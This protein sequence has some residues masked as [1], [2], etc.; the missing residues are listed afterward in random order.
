[1]FPNDHQF[2]AEDL[3]RIWI[4]Q[5]FVRCTNSRKT[6]EETGQEYFLD[7]ANLGVFEEVERDRAS[8][9]RRSHVMCAVMHDF[10]RIISRT[11]CESLDDCNEMEML[12]TIRHLSILTDSAYCKKDKHGS[13]PRNLQFEKKLRAV[14]T[15]TRKLRTLTLIGKYDSFFF[16]SFLDVLKKAPYLRMLQISVTYAE[17]SATLC[18][19]EKSTHLR[20]LKLKNNGSGE[21]LPIHLNKYYHLEVLDAGCPTLFHSMNDLVSM[22]Y[23][24]VKRGAH[25]FITSVDQNSSCFETTQLQS[26]MN[27]VQ[28]GVFQLGNVS[29]AEAYGAKLRDKKNMEMLHLSWKD[30]LSQDEYAS[31]TC[32]ESEDNN[33]ATSDQVSEHFTDTARG[34]LEGFEPHPNLKH[35]RI[36]GY[37]GGGTTFPD[38]LSSKFSVTCMQTLHLD[39]CGECQV[40]P[41]LEMLPFLTKLKL[42][43]MWKVTQVSIPSLEELVLIQMR[44]LEKCSCSSVRNLN[45]SLRVLVIKGCHKLKA[46]PLF[47][48][49][50]KFRI[51]QKSWLSGL[52]KLAIHDCPELIVSNPLPP[53][54]RSCKLSISRVST[55]PT[56]KGSSDGELIIG[57]YEEESRRDEDS[58]ELTELDDKILAFHNLRNLTSLKI[59]G[60]GNLVSIS[61]EGLRELISLETLIIDTCENLFPSTALP[62][63]GYESMAPDNFGALPS[64]KR[65]SF[66]DSG[67]AGKWLSLM[68]RHAPA[69]EELSLISCWQI[70]GL[71]VEEGESN[72]SNI[73]SAPEASSS[74]K[75]QPQEASSSRNGLLCIPPN[76]ISSLKN[77]CFEDCHELTFQGNKKGFS[78]FT[79]L[80]KLTI[81]CCPEMISSCVHN[82]KND[83]HAANARLLLPQSLV[84][85]VISDSPETLQLCF[86]GNL[87]CLKKI[88]LRWSPCLESLQLRHCTALEELRIGGCGSL[89]EVEGPPSLAGIRSLSVRYWPGLI[90]WFERLL[91]EGYDM[92]PRLVDLRVDDWSIL[93]T[94]SCVHLTSLE[95]L[96]FKWCGEKVTSHEQERA[97][98]LLTSLQELVFY[99][100]HYLEELPAVLHSLPSL[101]R[102]KIDCCRRISR[103]PEKGLPPSLE[104]LEISDC[105]EELTEQ[106]KK[107]ATTK[108]KVKID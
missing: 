108:L 106:C 39:N 35:L 88:H 64:L 6:L 10:A 57:A 97:L 47:G 58:D 54:S 4:S 78:E 86:P 37:S 32:S 81:I 96:E 34:V 31:D 44:N 28:L 50:E 61:L 2:L 95:S 105:S 43:K 20:Y 23:L 68:L 90:P 30:T 80:E 7:L 93:T 56:M 49:C 17:S 55:L 46:F 107:L 69:L 13:L 15:S 72:L 18:K 84:Q 82:D 38:W 67:I 52:S 92:R 25:S 1:M 65:L 94:S 48:S 101:K 60:C 36:S 77:M 9:D 22:R 85:L 100:C 70:T 73:S 103:L 87:T 66:F 8:D 11:E 19:L 26:M 42:K 89:T 71:L 76:L 29:R 75:P 98:Q 33:S 51:E 40:I 83:D 79:L 59:G 104:E 21:A 14:F 91:S 63:D 3:V 99:N 12:P 16:K 102:F 27:L 45:S 24:F 62:E 5:G 53:S 74:G 41:S